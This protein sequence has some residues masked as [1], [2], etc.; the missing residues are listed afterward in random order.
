M[1]NRTKFVFASDSHGEMVDKESAEE[2]FDFCGRYQPDIKVF[3]GDGF[4]FKSL[5]KGVSGKEE[6]GSM[7]DDIKLGFWFIKNYKPTIWQDGNHEH[8]LK[9]LKHDTNSGVIADHCDHLDRSISQMLKDNGCKKRLPY[10]YEKGVYTMGPIRTVHGYTVSD[11]AVAQ[12]AVHYG[13][14]GGAVLMGHLHRIEQVNAKKHMGVVGFSG[15]CLCRIEDMEYSETRLNTSTHGK[16]FLYGFYEGNHWKVWQAHKV[17][18]NWCYD[19]PI[20]LN[21]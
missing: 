15:G 2:L 3:G 20:T 1:A 16:G 19:V 17:G 14:A 6:S 11:R 21:K 5:R 7:S 10:H 18:K 4:D 12:H 9:R 8:R 13:V